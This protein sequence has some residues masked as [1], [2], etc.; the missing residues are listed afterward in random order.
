LADAHLIP[1]VVPRSERRWQ[2]RPEVGRPLL[3]IET[4]ASNLPCTVSVP[5]L[6]TDRP[7]LLVDSWLG[8]NV[9]RLMY[10]SLIWSAVLR[11]HASGMRTSLYSENLKRAANA[12]I[13]GMW[14][15]PELG[16]DLF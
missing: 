2:G 9:R 6:M 11:Y 1:G 14:R 16:G 15:D 4:D 13:D 7:H 10:Q 8:L 5:N 3:G 12:L